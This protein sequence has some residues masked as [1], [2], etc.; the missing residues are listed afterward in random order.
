M[1]ISGTR[2]C[3]RYKLFRLTFVMTAVQ[4]QASRINGRCRTCCGTTRRYLA[5]SVT[6]SEGVRLPRQQPKVQ[7]AISSLPGLGT[8][9]AP[10]RRHAP[11]SATA[12]AVISLTAPVKRAFID[13]L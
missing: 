13:S 8:S 10:G 1:P 4:L 7:P 9:R 11:V 12:T 5:P 2:S 6:G 3:L